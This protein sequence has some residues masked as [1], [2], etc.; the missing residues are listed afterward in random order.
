MWET[1]DLITIW[2]KPRPLEIL[3]KIVAKSMEVF[4]LQLSL[5]VV[6]RK[7]MLVVASLDVYSPV[8]NITKLHKGIAVCKPKY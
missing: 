6:E 8:F 2:T 5:E 3:E 4:S 7:W 1:T